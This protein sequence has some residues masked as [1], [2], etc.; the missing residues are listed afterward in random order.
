MA[1]LE[2]SVTDDKLSATVHTLNA[3][4]LQETIKYLAQHPEV[5][6]LE[7]LVI[8]SILNTFALVKKIT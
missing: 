7:F 3:S 5:K 8:F 1:E 4:N 6:R 2:L